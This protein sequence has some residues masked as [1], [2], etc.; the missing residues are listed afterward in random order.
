MKEI[1]DG[2]L[3]IADAHDNANKKSFLNFLK[4]LK[5]GA[6]LAPPQLFIMGD[7][8]DFLA[9]TTYSQLFYS[10]QIEI[11]NELSN[12]ID[13]YYFEGNHDFNL[14]NIFPNLKVFD[15]YSQPQIF[16]ANGEKISLAHG[17]IF[18]KP[19]ETFFLRS[20]RNRAFLW[21]M[22]KIDVFFKFKI[23]KSILK[24]QENKNLNY[25]IIDF[26]FV[27]GAKIHNY[28]TSKIIEG[29]YHQGVN[30]GIDDK[31]YINLPCFASEQRYFIV[32]YDHE[33]KFQIV[34]SPNV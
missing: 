30:L 10:E 1:L 4:A 18:L 13:I 11:L 25:K 2:A 21:L 9:N 7:M 31:I 32:E 19:F 34:R 24:A 33:I 8:F 6:I 12:D 26:A 14:K 20:L 16:N 22:D 5:S 29:H 3:F 27:I 23:S 28:Q 15:I 17:D